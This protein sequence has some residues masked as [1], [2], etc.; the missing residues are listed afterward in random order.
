VDKKF[1]T[2]KITINK[3]YTKKGDD[4]Y[5]SLIGG[6]KVKKNS[7]RIC[8]FGEI[9][10][11]NVLLGLCATNTEIDK[12]K[13]KS[14]IVKI[15][16]DLFNLGNMLAT[17]AEYMNSKNPQISENSVKF[18]EDYID[19]YNKKLDSLSSFILPGGSKTSIDFHIARVVCRRCERLIVG[20]RETDN[21][22]LIIIK[23]LNRLSD[24]LFVWGRY[25]NFILGV[26]E[27]LW[28]PNYKEN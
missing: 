19:I 2:P 7:A 16:N 22:D 11:L 28:N 1:K 26:E 12:L 18:L 27:V 20:M 14:K 9:D 6:E 5:T 3:V 21:I 25:S 8:G 13:I 15:Q 17:P 23:Y 4:G 24:L 10:E